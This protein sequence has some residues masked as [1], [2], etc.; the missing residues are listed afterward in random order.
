MEEKLK[1]LFDFQRFEEN[2]RLASLIKETKDRET[3]ELSDD[4]LFY[5]AAAGSAEYL[6]EE[7]EKKK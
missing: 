7:A 6:R 4:D 1:K 3:R 2:P 5:V